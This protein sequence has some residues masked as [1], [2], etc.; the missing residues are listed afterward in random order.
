MGNLKKLLTLRI[1][2]LTILFIFA[3]LVIFFLTNSTG[4]SAQ[5]GSGGCSPTLTKDV[6]SIPIGQDIEPGDIVEITIKLPGCNEELR[7]PADTMLVMDQSGSMNSP[8]PPPAGATRLVAAKNA[9][10]LFVDNTKEDGGLTDPGDYTGL[11]TFS[12]L[13]GTIGGNCFVASV[14]ARLNFPITNMTVANK[15]AIKNT[16]DS[17]VTETNTPIGSGLDLANKE[18]LNLVNPPPLPPPSSPTPS[19]SRDNVNKYIVLASDGVQNEPPS[20]YQNNILQTAID[21]GIVIF[22]VGISNEI[23]DTKNINSDC[24]G[25]P[26]IPNIP[27]SQTSGEMIL[28][29]IACRTDQQRPDPADNCIMVWNTSNSSSINDLDNPDHY[30]FGDDP[31][32]LNQIYQEIANEIKSTASYQVLDTVNPNVFEKIVATSAADIQVYNCLDPSKSP[33]PNTK[34]SLVGNKGFLITVSEIG[35][36]INVCISFKAQIHQASKTVFCEATGTNETFGKCITES[37]NTFPVDDARIAST[38]D[39]DVDCDSN[40][41]GVITP[42]IELTPCAI[43]MFGQS[44]VPI[45]EGSIVIENPAK[46]WLK[47]TEGDVGSI[48][49]IGPIARNLDSP[50][51]GAGEFNAEYLVIQQD[52]TLIDGNF[53]AKW[54][55]NDYGG[56]EPVSGSIYDVLRA[57]YDV[58]GSF[59]GVAPTDIKPKVTANCRIVE[60]SGGSL[61]INAAS[62]NTVGYD[63]LPAVVFVK[64][65]M[66]I[67]ENMEIAAGTGI[68]FIVN[69]NLIIDA[70]VDEVD[71]FFIFDGDFDSNGTGGNEEQLVING[72][73]VGGFG[74]G[75]LKF[76][77][78]LDSDNLNQAAEVVNYEPKYLWL[79][80]DIAGD[81]NVIYRE[82]AP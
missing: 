8:F 55:I 81:T 78:D 21:N 28:K 22:T 77:R 43:L 52:S 76:E 31:T 68:I 24:V 46:P 61:T 34:K 51:A 57:K 42:N 30:Y 47:T 56:L 41:D 33:W 29:D 66:N 16:I 58:C 74:G 79:F 5:G 20:P 48:G 45:P 64:G 37:G 82:V 12:E 72:A 73:V 63:G 11:V 40:G 60:F 25:C 27:G 14:C 53:V 10:K 35:S 2:L 65:D 62:W 67:R 59:S 17:M 36:D 15:T 75:T 50:S 38:W 70:D 49:P 3:S 54:K 23:N 44:N 13:K 9:L 39:L 19:T 7:D 26:D 4:T 6:G 18:L 80:Q 1:F 32:K 71:G 69:G